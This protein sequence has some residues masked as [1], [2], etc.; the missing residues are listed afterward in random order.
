MDQPGLRSKRESQ[1]FRVVKSLIPF[2][3]REDN[4]QET[5]PEAGAEGH[6]NSFYLFSQPGV[7]P[8][9]ANSFPHLDEVQLCSKVKG[10]VGDERG[11]P[12]HLSAQF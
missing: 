1:M 8:C 2:Y 9:S 7:K 3:T 11:S 10:V 4:E 5:L 6:E 12:V